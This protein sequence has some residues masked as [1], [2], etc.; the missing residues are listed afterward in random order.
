MKVF[1]Y[2]S[3]MSLVLFSSCDLMGNEET[4]GVEL[5]ATYEGRV[6]QDTQR[7]SVNEIRGGQGSTYVH[8]YQSPDN[9]DFW[10]WVGDGIN[11]NGDLLGYYA[12]N[13]EE[14]LVSLLGLFDDWNY[15]IE[16]FEHG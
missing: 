2:I 9:N 5:I 14:G 8:V 3:F 10:F 16:V 7:I 11:D 12:I 4:S 13:W 1:V 6:N 15:R